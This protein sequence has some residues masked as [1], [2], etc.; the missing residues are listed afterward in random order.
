M[1]K[2]KSALPWAIAMLCIALLSNLGWIERDAAR[3][4]LIVLPAL[5]ITVNMA[6]RFGRCRLGRADMTE[7]SE[8]IAWRRRPAFYGGLM[9]ARLRRDRRPGTSAHGRSTPWTA[10]ILMIAT[11][12]LSIPLVRITQQRQ[13]DCGSASFGGNPLYQAHSG[14]GARLYRRARHSP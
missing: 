5:A 9:I 14:F 8:R 4:M 12:M 13:C 11:M 2:M 6:S 10:T 1:S 7:P 3:T